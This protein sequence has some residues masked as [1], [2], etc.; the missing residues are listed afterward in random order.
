MSPEPLITIAL[1]AF[2]AERTIGQAIRSVLLQTY[3]NWELM[4]ADDGSTDGTA[5]IAR[6]FA[7]PRIVILPSSGRE[8]LSRRLNACIDRAK[9]TYLARMDADDVSYPVR[10]EKQIAFLKEHPSVD[11]VGS[12]AMVFGIEGRPIGKRSSPCVHELITKNP[13]Y[14]FRMIH[15]SWMGQLTWFRKYRYEPEAV[16]CEDHDLL[17]R[18]FSES[19][20]ANLPDILLG[21]REEKL[22]LSKLMLSRWTQVKRMAKQYPQNIKLSGLT[23]L[24]LSVGLKATLDC[25]A[26]VTGLEHRLVRQRAQRANA[27]E[28]EEW[29]Y[30]WSLTQELD[31]PPSPQNG[32]NG[33]RQ[34]Q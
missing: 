21:Y 7:D 9:G 18:A 30:V 13:I 2:N 26:V 15:P 1:P 34:T 31:V 12:Q 11:L 27:N 16:R 32:C 29:R 17:L 33:I 10:F 5:G 22:D 25:A 4:L 19:V 23:G 8:G 28:I 6:S 24:A 20:Y 3:G 14:G